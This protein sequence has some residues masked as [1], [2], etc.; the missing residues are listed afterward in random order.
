MVSTA[1]AVAAY[2]LRV[3]VRMVLKLE[4]NM[5]A[6]G[7]RFPMYGKYEVTR[8]TIRTTYT[9]FAIQF[10]YIVNNTVDS[11]YPFDNN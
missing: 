7:K 5:E 2:N 3:P 1:C 4:T 10:P 11:A 9:F 6:V 8:I